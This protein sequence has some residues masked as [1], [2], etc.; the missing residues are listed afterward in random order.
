MQHDSDKAQMSVTYV[1]TMYPKILKGLRDILND[2]FTKVYMGA[3][4]EHAGREAV[5]IY[6]N[7]P[8]SEPVTQSQ[9]FEERQYN[10]L[11][12]HYW[13]DKDDSERALEQRLNRLDR[14]RR[15]LTNNQNNTLWFNLA[16]QEFD[17]DVDGIENEE[18]PQL[19]IAEFS[20]E[21]LNY[22]VYQ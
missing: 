12:R 1:K 13:D 14:L 2:D 4:K 16:V 11:I 7:K 6:F 22:Q 17:Q 8:A 21:V 10:V 20:I 19:K 9:M 15:V 5:Q 18:R 3:Y